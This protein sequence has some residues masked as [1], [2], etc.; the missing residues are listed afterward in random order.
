MDIKQ[1][2]KDRTYL[3]NPENIQLVKFLGNEWGTDATLTLDI[4]LDEWRD[5]KA[6]DIKLISI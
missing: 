3:L 2:Y 5:C 6:D 4:I 1:K